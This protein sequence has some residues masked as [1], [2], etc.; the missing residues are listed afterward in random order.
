L[1]ARARIVIA[2][3]RISDSC[4]YGVPLFGYEGERSQLADWAD[5]KGPEGIVRYREENNRRSIDGL[6]GLR[7]GSV[8][9]TRRSKS[10]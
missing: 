3:E 9:S 2:L 10:G 7:G 1:R 8:G 6:E 4:G 5:R